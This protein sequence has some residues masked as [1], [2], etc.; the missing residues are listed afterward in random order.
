MKYTKICKE[1]E[2]PFETNRSRQVFCCVQ[3]GYKYDRRRR[4]SNRKPFRE[5][6]REKKDR[7]NERRRILNKRDKLDLY[8]F[9]GNKCFHCD[10]SDP[11]ALQI[12]HV[13]GGGKKE[14]VTAGNRGAYYRRVLRLLKEGSK[15]YQLLCAN[16]NWIK[17]HNNN[18]K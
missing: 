8:D 4:K 5:W 17:R 6:T 13:N 18:E 14:L 3:H 9:L 11:R 10:F 1:C 15:E 12:D 2:I 16:C 7:S